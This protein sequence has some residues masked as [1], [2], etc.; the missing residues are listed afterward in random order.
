MVTGRVPFGGEYEQ[1]V[2]YAILNEPPR[3]LDGEGTFPLELAKVIDQA[4]EKDPAA[5]YPTAEAMAEDL[6]QIPLDASG[7]PSHRRPAKT[8][9]WP[10][11]FRRWLLAGL[12]VLT[13][14]GIALSV[15]QWR[16]R[17]WEFSP[18][19]ARLIEQ[20]DRLEWRGDTKRILSNAEHSYRQALALD[21]DN[22]LIEAHLAALLTRV[23]A[24]FPVAG[25]R[26]EIRQ[27][28]A[29]AVERAPDLPLPWVAQG[30]LLLLEDK[31]REAEQAAREAI[32]RDPDFDRGY[33]VLGEALIAQGQLEEGLNE[34][35]RG[36][37]VGQ[38]YLRARLVL[39]AKLQDAS[40]YD[41]A[42]AELRR[43]LTYD[44]DHPTAKE[45][46]GAIY[47]INSR[48][49]DAIP[50]FREVFEATHDSR[51]ANSLGIAYFNLNRM[52]EAI[53]AFGEAYRLDPSPTMARNLAES[54][55]KIGQEKGARRWYALAL[56]SFDRMLALSSQR[57]ELLN[58]RAF[59]AAKLGRYDEA[60]GNVQ[61]AIKLKPK[62]NAFLFRIAQIFSMAGRREEVYS[63]M[64]KAVQAGYSREDFR[65]DLAFRDFQDDPRFREI[66]ESAAR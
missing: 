59:C 63:Y 3:I 43:V 36:V 61:E 39:A 14:V 20:G 19:V 60:L 57:A 8:K 46:L 28:T 52:D 15:W 40:R 50:L 25:R 51:S 18:E 64:R 9:H 16:E 22:P 32:E 62:Q 47:L 10:P 34:I 23:D 38:G 37:E 13:V 30:K 6:A 27:L 58:S 48:Y 35:R 33:T 7:E 45:N 65:R 11:P 24:Q 4:L 42:A 12:A 31:P 1:A 55:E 44:P 41:E 29:L 53:K 21:R 66:L 49:L 2:I 54:Y 26:R 56:E 17:R 5:R